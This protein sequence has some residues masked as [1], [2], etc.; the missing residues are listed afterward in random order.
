[1]TTADTS[2][3]NI[4]SEATQLIVAKNGDNILPLP[5]TPLTMQL[6]INQNE[7]TDDEDNE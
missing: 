6:L 1:M 5:L 7:N 3:T 4:S 2:I